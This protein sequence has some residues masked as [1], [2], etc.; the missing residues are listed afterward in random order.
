MRAVVGELRDL[1]LSVTD[2]AFLT[3]VS[4]GRVS[5]LLAQDPRRGRRSGDARPRSD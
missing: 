1:G 5:Q 4:R 3:H 2:I